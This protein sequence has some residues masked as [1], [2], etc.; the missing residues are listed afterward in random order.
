MEWR[1][2]QDD[3]VV[4]VDVR[5][6]ERGCI[7]EAMVEGGRYFPALQQYSVDE[8]HVSVYRNDGNGNCFHYALLQGAF[9]TSSPMVTPS[10]DFRKLEQSIYARC[11]SWVTGACPDA[12]AVGCGK[13]TLEKALTTSQ[14]SS[15]KSMGYPVKNIGRHNSVET[16]GGL[17]KHMRDMIQVAQ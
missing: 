1:T 8:N 10:L 9:L 16:I 14:I 7:H 11:F 13:L 4:A 15:L 5:E 2:P 12:L 3:D 17:R 6:G